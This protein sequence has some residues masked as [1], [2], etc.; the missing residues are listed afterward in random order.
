MERLESGVYRHYKEGR[1]YLLLFTAKAPRAVEVADEDLLVYL[2]GAPGS[3][4]T[5]T[6]PFVQP[7]KTQSGDI[8]EHLGGR[9]VALF[10]AR[11][12]GPIRAGDVVC[13]YVP[14]YADKPGRRIS[15]RPISEWTEMVPKASIVVP[16]A[17][18]PAVVRVPR[19]TYVGQ[20]VS[21]S[22]A[23]GHGG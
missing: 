11:S 19:F 4:A 18:T 21:G 17:P 1:F 3:F 7:V 12:H 23:I 20:T 6:G 14:L 13:V 2:M 9:G 5:P 15:V 16:S 8:A 22:E 10:I